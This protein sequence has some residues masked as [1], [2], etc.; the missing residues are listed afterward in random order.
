MGILL[1]YSQITLELFS[2]GTNPEV[3][4]A[5]LKH[6]QIMLERHSAKHVFDDEYRQFY[7]R[8]NEPPYVKHLKVDILP[9]LG[10]SVNAKVF[11]VLVLCIYYLNCIFFFILNISSSF[12]ACAHSKKLLFHCHE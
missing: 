12:N 11:A 10:N 6:L 2:T 8:Y 5:V 4:Y 9:L 3:Q 1:Y 7:V